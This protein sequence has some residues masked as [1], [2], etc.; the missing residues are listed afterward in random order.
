MHNPHT[1]KP[2]QWF[3][4]VPGEEQTLY[5][6]DS[7]GLEG[8]QGTDVPSEWH[9]SNSSNGRGSQLCLTAQPGRDEAAN[10][11]FLLSSLRSGCGMTTELGAQW[12]SSVPSISAA[13]PG[14][15]TTTPERLLSAASFWNAARSVR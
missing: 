6:Q 14:G 10:S 13:R 4:W 12:A 1:H 5:R 15:G 2:S 8:E 3:G 9:R 7:N 11:R